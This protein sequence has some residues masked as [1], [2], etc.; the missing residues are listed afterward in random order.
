MSRAQKFPA[1]NQKTPTL[2]NRNCTHISYTKSLEET[3][4]LHTGSRNGSYVTYTKSPDR[5]NPTIY[6][7][8]SR[9][10][11]ETSTWMVMDRSEKLRRRNKRDR[12]RR[13]QETKKSAR[14][15]WTKR[16]KVSAIKKTII[17]RPYIDLQDCSLYIMNH[18]Y[19][20]R[21]GSP[22]NALASV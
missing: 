5:E 8:N 15:W 3:E 21:S 12:Q 18:V 6:P 7:K 17:M 2:V 10:N 1:R 14:N 20:H 16:S 19:C 22:H 13:A 9:H 4:K 11:N